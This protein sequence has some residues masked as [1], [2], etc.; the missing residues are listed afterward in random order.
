[1]NMIWESLRSALSSIRAHGLRSFLTTLGII[2]GVASVIAVV[3]LIQGLSHSIT[4]QFEGLGGNSITVQSDTSLQEAMQGKRNR[5]TLADFQA[6]VHHIDGIA[7]VTP[8]FVVNIG[9]DRMLRYQG[10]NAFTQVLATRS[11][12]ADSRQIYPA[13][14]RFLIAGDEAS[15]RRVVIIGE[16]VRENL[17]LPE[18]PIGEFI[19]MGGEWFKVVGITEKRGEMF[20][21][22]QDDY[23]VIPFA[24]GMAAYADPV[25]QDIDISFT[26]A[27]IA[28]IEPVKDRITALL[29]QL[30][31]LKPGERNDFKVQTASQLTES[32]SQV[33]ATVTLVL[34]GIVSVSLLVGGIGIMNIMLVSVTERTREI[35]ISKALG[36]KR[37][38]ILLQFLIEATVLSVLGGLVGILLGYGLGFGAAKLLPGFPDAFVPWWAIALAFGFSTLV[39]VIFGLMPAAKAAKLDPIDALRYE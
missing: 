34:G 12:F 16:T 15:R 8:L 7:D 1:M 31:K 4:S 22:S 21:F 36:A 25:R 6:I 10:Q 39:G 33:I 9:G 24:T 32:F 19:E 35:G 2:I 30:H 11:A 3:S 29:R 37:H 5:L 28:E 38:H 17:K 14:G 18:D 13:L 26:V 27:D 20:G 23:V